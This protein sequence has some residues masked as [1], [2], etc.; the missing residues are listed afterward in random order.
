[1]TPQK[2]QIAQLI[3]LAKVDG[4]LD[5]KEV[6]L[7]Y[8][9]ANKHGFTK[10]EMD[11]IIELKDDELLSVPA[12]KDDRIRFFYQLLILA[13]V[14][15][16]VSDDEVAFL[17]RIGGKFQLDPSKVTKAIAHI[18]ANRETDLDHDSIQ[19]IFS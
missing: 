17:T 5:S 4:E 9:L 15:F 2:S 10:F 8:G 6:M 13:T 3:R 1:M 18:I 19:L 16:E 11:E 14:D 12:T 7:I